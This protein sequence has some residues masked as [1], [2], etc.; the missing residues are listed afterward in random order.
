[1][2]SSI[3]QVLEI[4]A[5]ILLLGAVGRGGR[6]AGLESHWMPGCTF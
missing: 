5:F 2:V 1:M 6:R 4:V 3:A